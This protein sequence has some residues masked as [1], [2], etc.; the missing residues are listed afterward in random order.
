MASVTFELP[1]ELLAVLPGSPQGGC[2]GYSTRGRP[3]LVQSRGTLD[4]VGCPA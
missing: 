3:V 4:G 1:D 2:R